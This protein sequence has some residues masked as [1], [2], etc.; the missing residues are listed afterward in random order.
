MTVVKICGIT[1][2]DDARCASLAGADLLGFIFYPAS[3]R[4]L[5]PRDAGRIATALHTEFG[6]DRPRLVGVFVDAPLP[7]IHLVIQAAR[8]DL[9]QLHGTEPAS[10][11][12]ALQPVAFK[13]VRPRNLPDAQEALQAYAG[14]W[15]RH[16]NN[17][18]MPHLLVDAYHHEQRGGTGAKA[19]INA[20]HW[21]AARCRIMLAG[22]L[23]PDNI[24]EAIETLHPWGVDV[25][26][27]VERAKG[28]KDHDRLFAFVQTVRAMEENSALAPDSVR[29]AQDLRS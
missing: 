8:L 23:D 28:L 5:A 29:R 14:V 16:R 18:N 2:I 27:G 11:V 20:V 25:S 9:V 6:V 7:L 21:L 15:S 1:N 10:T 4:Y 22:G 26:S 19:E 17:E 13:A 3:P 24:A 12:A